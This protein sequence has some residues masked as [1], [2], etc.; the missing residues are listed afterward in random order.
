MFSHQNEFQ[1]S[2]FDPSNLSNEDRRP[3][4]CRNMTIVN[5][6]S[7]LPMEDC[8]SEQDREICNECNLNQLAYMICLSCVSLFCES[9]A[10]PHVSKRVCKGEVKRFIN[11]DMLFQNAPL[12]RFHSNTTCSIFCNRCL[13]FACQKC[14]DETGTSPDDCK[15]HANTSRTLFAGLRTR[16][17]GAIDE[18]FF[19]VE[20]FYS[21]SEHAAARFQQTEQIFPSV[22]PLHFQL[23]HEAKKE[24]FAHLIQKLKK[25][26]DH[27]VRCKEL[28]DEYDQRVET[29]V[30]DTIKILQI[31]NM[32]K[33]RGFY[34]ELAQKTCEFMNRFHELSSS[35]LSVGLKNIQEEVYRVPLTYHNCLASAAYA[36]FSHISSI[37]YSGDFGKDSRLMVVDK[38]RGLCHLIPISGNNLNFLCAP[39]S[40]PYDGSRVAFC[41]KSEKFLVASIGQSGEV[42]GFDVGGNVARFGN[43]N[44]HIEDVCVGPD[45]EVVLLDTKLKKLTIIDSNHNVSYVGLHSTLFADPIAAAATTNEYLLVLERNACLVHIID[46]VGTAVFSFGGPEYLQSPVAMDH[47]KTTGKTFVAS[48]LHGRNFVTV[49]NKH[50]NLEHTFE[51]TG[52]QGS[53]TSIRST[54]AGPFFVSTTNF[55]YVF[56]S[57][58]LR[59]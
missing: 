18:A 36:P 50:Y 24:L 34:N 19:W 8:M 44:E 39:R 11:W 3:H 37:A 15:T 23:E 10:E 35:E 48:V 1:L 30:A 32:D 54:S 51:L 20:T 45:R 4:L 52:M 28:A 29:S 12:C 9:C 33:L 40:L 22:F 2:T 43:T 7:D 31:L 57:W 47:N 46:L 25:T 16:S 53:L 13:S 21:L 55:V 42:V 38:C 26:A 14:A 59:H 49:Y 5:G 56:G 17:R 6:A 27:L 58:S 41:N